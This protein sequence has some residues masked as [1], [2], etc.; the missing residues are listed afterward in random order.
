MSIT[1]CKQQH[2]TRY[3]PNCGKQL[4]GDFTLW[5]LLHHCEE[6]ATKQEEKAER[7]KGKLGIRGQ[8]REGH[9]RQM[10]QAAKKWRTW[11]TLLRKHLVELPDSD[12]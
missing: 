6:N 5:G 9:Q 10:E 3:C 12:A 1:C 11:A 7:H 4:H 8:P 2:D